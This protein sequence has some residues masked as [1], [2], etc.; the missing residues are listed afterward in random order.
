LELLTAVTVKISKFFL[1]HLLYIAVHSHYGMQ[2]GVQKIVH[3]HGP[4]TWDTILQISERFLKTSEK[5]ITHFYDKLQRN[6]SSSL[7]RVSEEVLS[8]L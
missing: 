8:M 5:Y 7:Y 3:V 4:L 6:L 1:D 2:C